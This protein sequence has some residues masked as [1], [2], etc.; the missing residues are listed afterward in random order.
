MK[1]FAFHY[2]NYY[3]GRRIYLILAETSIEAEDVLFKE[4]DDAY[5]KDEETDIDYID[6][7]SL[8]KAGLIMRC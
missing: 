3:E 2:N 7:I 1:L 5:I 8:D 4:A 6:E